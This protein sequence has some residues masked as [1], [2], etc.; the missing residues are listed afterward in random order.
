M[1]ATKT[2]LSRLVNEG[3]DSDHDVVRQVYG[4][5]DFNEGVSAFVARRSPAWQGR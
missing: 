2:V 5:A 1:A 4:S 3:D